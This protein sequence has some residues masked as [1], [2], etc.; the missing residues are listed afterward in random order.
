[1]FLRLSLTVM[2]VAHVDVLIISLY[3]REE[4][5]KF[6]DLP[7]LPLI[8]DPKQPKVHF[9]FKGNNLQNVFKFL[10]RENNVQNVF[11]IS[12]QREHHRRMTR[13]EKM[14]RGWRV[15]NYI[16]LNVGTKN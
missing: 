12:L 11:K 8:S 4:E 14:E 9:L 16:S 2:P 3:T 6:S 13:K 1:M 15:K 5:L 7:R 10:F